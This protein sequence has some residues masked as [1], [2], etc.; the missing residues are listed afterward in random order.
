MH[1]CQPVV[2]PESLYP[3]KVQQYESNMW[4]TLKNGCLE[5]FSAKITRKSCQNHPN[6]QTNHVF[7]QVD[8][9]NHFA[10]L[11]FIIIFHHKTT[12]VF[13]RFPETQ[14]KRFAGRL[15]CQDHMEG[16]GSGGLV[17]TVIFSDFTHWVM[18]I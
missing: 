12:V 5:W 10:A 4:Y 8:H 16:M 9:E 2:L 11:P 14:R 18:V 3:T 6:I 13:V 15:H 1:G 7:S 17:V